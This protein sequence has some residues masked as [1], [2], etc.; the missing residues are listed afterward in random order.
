MATCPILMACALHAQ[1]VEQD[2]QTDYR[3]PTASGLSDKITAR[4]QRPILDCTRSRCE[5]WN[6]TAHQCG[7]VCPITPPSTTGGSS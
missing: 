2:Q 7:L 1:L 5:W 6:Q 3:R 4:L